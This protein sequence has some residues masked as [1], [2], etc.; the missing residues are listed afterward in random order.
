MNYEKKRVLHK[1]KYGEGTII[2]QDDYGNIIVQFD[3]EKDV[4]IFRAPDCFKRFL[5]LL[6]SEAANNAAA[7]IKKK[8]ATEKEKNGQRQ[9]EEL[10]RAHSKHIDANKT[11]DR[12]S[13]SNTAMSI[14]D[15]YSIQSNQIHKE[16]AYLRD[17]GGKRS[18]LFDGTLVDVKNGVYI[19]SFDSDSELNLPDSTQITLWP[20]KL[21]SGISASILNCEDFTVIITTATSLGQSVSSIEYSAETWR[22]LECLRERLKT[23]SEQNNPI[24]NSL[25]T[26]AHRQIQKGKSISK[27]QNTACRMSA[28]QPITVIWGPPGTGKT[29]TLAN[30]ALQHLNMGHRVLMLS[31]SNVSVDGAILRVFQKDTKKRRGKLVRY[32]YPRDKSILQHNYLTSYQLTLSN[33]PIQS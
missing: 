1:T 7:A 9:R 22:L 15:F 6:D 24:V 18:K 14:D 19:Y 33:H 3:S 2:S 20:S 16:I 5:Q 32:G 30:I 23:M 27:G 26:S 13:Y 12:A 4:K 25:I 21:S 8:D 28:S 29:E 10:L 31:Y 17:N 11:Q